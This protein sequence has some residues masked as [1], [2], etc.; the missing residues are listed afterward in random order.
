MS[1]HVGMNV[2]LKT[3]MFGTTHIERGK[4]VWKMPIRSSIVIAILVGYFV[5]TDRPMSAVPLAIGALFA[6]VADVG[7]H[8][9]YRWRTMLWTTTWLMLGCAVADLVSDW[10]IL[11]VVASCAVALLTGFVGAIGMRAGLIGTLVLVV[12]TENHANERGI[13]LTV[14]LP[15]LAW[16]SWRYRTWL[17][18]GGFVLVLLFETGLVGALKVAI[19]RSFPYQG[20][21]VLEAGFLAFPSGHAGNV[22]ALWG[23]CAWYFARRRP[24]LRTVLSALSGGSHVRV[25]F[26]DVG[27]R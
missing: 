7:E 21:M 19:G 14:C 27:E 5:W 3:V 9:G 12:F 13:I 8:L 6:A 11:V 25:D 18:V 10:R 4:I 17:P 24:A 2:H 16:R 20:P 15:W 22:V 23:F 26:L 1:S